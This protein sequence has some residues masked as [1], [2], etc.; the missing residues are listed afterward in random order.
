MKQLPDTEV[1]EQE[2]DT[3][4][5][6]TTKPDSIDL[7]ES[8]QKN[9]TEQVDKAKKAES[10]T[11]DESN[12]TMYF[13]LDEQNG[14]RLVV[15]DAAAGSR[16]YVMERTADGGDTWERINEDPFDNQAGVAEGVMFLDDN[17]GI[18]GLAGAS[19][20]HST[21][22]ITKDGGRSFGEIKLPM[23]T[24]TELPE[25]AKEHG[26]TVEDYDY[27][28][29]PQIGATTLIIMVTTDKGDNDGIVFESE[30]GGDT[31]K[32]RGVTQN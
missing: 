17:F 1:A 19:Q 16:F 10:W 3:S 23:S 32:Y 5:E 28:N 15:V 25:S 27:L 11:M 20:S 4:V 22:Y 21:L 8:N 24:V 18:A 29:M 9:I 12:G 14:W 7:G 13:F 30:D 6:Y 2:N 26:F 31:W